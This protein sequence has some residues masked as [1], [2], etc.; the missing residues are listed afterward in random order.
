MASKK[1]STLSYGSVLTEENK[2]IAI[3]AGSYAYSETAIKLK[4]LKDY[5]EKEHWTWRVAGL[6][7]GLLLVSTS[8]L[9]LVSHLFGLS[10]ISML[11]DVYV[12]LFG[13]VLCILECKDLL[14][15]ETV[16]ATIK[17]EALFLYRP[18]GRGAFYLFVGLLLIARGSIISML[19]G[20]YVSAIGAIIFV[21]SRQAFSA[22]ES[23]RATMKSESDVAAKFAQFDSDG[24]GYLDVGELSKLCQ[25]M[26]ADQSLNELESALFV[27]DK[28]DDGKISYE[29]F[30]D[31]W[32]ENDPTHFV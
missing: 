30:L 28:N 16:R 21:V 26:G 2:N 18:Y 5:A 4:E 13:I 15:P 8:L 3:N 12:L 23:M 10:P 6:I 29:E 19:S 1:S 7:A 14:L 9:S 31:W 25:S 32:R 27:L 24:S 20:F 22:L 11:L 17:R